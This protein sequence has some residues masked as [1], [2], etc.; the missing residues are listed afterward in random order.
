MNMIYRYSAPISFGEEPCLFDKYLV[1][2]PDIKNN[3]Y[4]LNTY[5]FV[6]FKVSQ[7]ETN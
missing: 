3:K 2:N 4:Y 1:L 6:N 7:N 5:F